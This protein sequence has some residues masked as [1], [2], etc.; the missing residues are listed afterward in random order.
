[1][2]FMMP[3]LMFVMNGVSILIVWAGAH[4]VDVAE[5][6]DRRYAGVS[7]VR[8]ACYHVIPLH[9]DDVHHDAASSGF[10]ASE[11]AEV[12]D[13]EPADRRSGGCLKTVAAVTGRD[14]GFRSCIIRLSGC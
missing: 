11:S 9:H 8:D 3:A 6:D 5:P 12:L 4:L 2:S 1:M 7:A 14:R 10:H 13:V